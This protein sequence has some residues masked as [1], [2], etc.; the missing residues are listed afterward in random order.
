MEIR[1]FLTEF[2]FMD[3]SF[4]TIHS[5]KLSDGY[6]DMVIS[7]GDMTALTDIIT[8]LIKERVP[9][10]GLKALLPS[11]GIGDF[12]N[13][14][15]TDMGIDPNVAATY[16]INFTQRVHSHLTRLPAAITL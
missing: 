9:L 12:N 6:V 13:I 2:D 11:R 10:Y 14:I 5:Y 7:S 16:A 15:F 4:G 8:K 1:Y 3:L